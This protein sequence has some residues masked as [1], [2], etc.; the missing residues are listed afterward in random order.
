MFEK[1]T[2]VMQIMVTNR[3]EILMLCRLTLGLLSVVFS[4]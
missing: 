3:V 1:I 4:Q 2:T